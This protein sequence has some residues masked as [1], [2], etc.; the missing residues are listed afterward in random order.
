MVECIGILGGVFTQVFFSFLLRMCCF[1]LTVYD[2]LRYRLLLPRKPR[3][4][5]ATG[6][7][8]GADARMEED[9]LVNFHSQPYFPN[10]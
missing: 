5:M 4:S 8:S 6:L 7:S 10:E 1:W 9:Y 3:L 2:G